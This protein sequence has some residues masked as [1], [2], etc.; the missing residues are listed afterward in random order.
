MSQLLA[1]Y[2]STLGKKVAMAVTGIILFGYVI[3][4]MLGNLQIYLGPEPLNAYAEFLHGN[5]ALLWAVRLLL[6]LAV[7]VHIV[8]SVQVWLRNRASRPVKY[9]RFRPPE[10]DYAART[11]IWSGPIVAAFVVYHVL[12]LTTGT[13]H[14]DYRYLDV[15]HNV[16]TGFMQ[17]L[18]SAFYIVANLLLAV[19]LYHGMWSLFQ[20]MGWEHPRYN[21]WRRWFAVAFAVVIGA[22]NISI[23]VAV[24]TGLVG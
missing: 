15:Y 19:H 20:T 10:A 21:A 13:V 2:R 8:A 6:L 5:Q 23:P 9:R 17:P 12:H 16:T 4:H 1:L 3:G 24:L 11:M 22:G 7:V 14:P 18:V